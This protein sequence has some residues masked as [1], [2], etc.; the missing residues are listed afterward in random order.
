MTSSSKIVTMMAVAVVGLTACETDLFDAE[1]YEALVRASFPV[2]DVDPDHTWSTMGTG[3]A[4]ITVL[5]DYGQSYRVSVYL[6]NPLVTKPV[7]SLCSGT[8]ESGS[9]MEAS[10]T[11][12]LANSI[13]YIGYYD[14]DG[15][16]LVEMAE[17]KDGR[18][19]ATVG[20]SSAAASRVLRARES[21]YTGSY[22]KQLTD[23]LNPTTDLWGNTLNTQPISVD[24]MKNYTP[25][26]DSDLQTQNTITNANYV[27]NPQTYNT[28][29][30]YLCGGDGKHYRVAANTEIFQVFHAN[31][32]YGVVNDVVVY[33]EGKLHLNGNTLNGLTLVVAPGGEI[34]IDGNTNMSNAGRFV[35]MAGGSISGADGVGL[36][37]NNGGI[38]YNAGSIEYKGELNVNGSDFYNCGS[39]NVD[40][41]RNTSGGK[42][43]NFGIIV[44]RTNNIAGDSYNSTVVNGCYMHFTGDA[45]IGSLTMLEESRLDVDGY[46]EFTQSF[47]NPGYNFNAVVL[48]K[49]SMINVGVAY[50]TSTAFEGPASPDEFAIVKMR[51]VQVGNGYD[52]MQY[53]NCYFDWDITE[54]YNK[55]GGKGV[56]TEGHKL[57]ATYPESANQ[58]VKTHIKK[59]VFEATAPE[60]FI[61]PA[62]DCTGS[63]Y[64]AEGNSG[65]EITGETPLQLRYCFEDNF[66]EVGDYD[67]NDAVITVTPTVDGTTATLVVSL[68][69]VGAT[70]QLAAALRIKGLNTSRIQSCT[71]TGNLD[72]DFPTNALTRIINTTDVL[73][74]SEL[75]NTTDA[76]FPLFNSAHWAIG[77]HELSAMGSVNTYFYNTVERNNAYDMKQND[78]A[79]ATVTFTIQLTN[80]D[81]AAFFTKDHLDVFILEGYNAGYWEVHTV[82]FKTDEVLKPYVKG[83]SQRY[84]DN[85]PWAICVPGNTFKYPIEWQ[86]I[87]SKKDGVISGAYATPGHSFA[88]WAENHQTA[89]DWY[90]YPTSGLVYE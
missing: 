42:F 28:D 56:V 27:W 30:V 57:T 48:M 81:D 88:E 49:N 87:G 4:A 3:T 79:P 59:F 77:R 62:G 8:V 55:D 85:M 63:G 16:R 75:N 66:P 38:C 78:V 84:T 40:L 14:S 9:T 10:F 70:K 82:P 68:D 71:R 76:V 7:I 26:T 50:V 86:S 18:I 52:I 58:F 1:R 23:Y 74:P 61:I 65:G 80:E 21:D 73:L 22:A 39:V 34:V 32:T 67:F 36:Y 41:L 45:G 47:Y 12:P 29:I 69:A 11:Y 46:A 37:V 25:F 2:E 17:M 35:V 72:Q 33:V 6:D 64:N 60:N 13:F 44:A 20:R 53:N 83:L 19:E 5:G 51:A 31:A 54:I 15:R 90:N 24:A 89:T 43:T